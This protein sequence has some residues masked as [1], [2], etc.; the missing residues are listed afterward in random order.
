VLLKNPEEWL[1]RKEIGNEVTQLQPKWEIDKYGYIPASSIGHWL[2]KLILLHKTVE[3]DT[4]A[5]IE[6]F[7]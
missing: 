2:R 5:R 6:Y 1:T 7:V 3:V 4:M